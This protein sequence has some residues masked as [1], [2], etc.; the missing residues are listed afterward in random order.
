[1]NNQNAK[2]LDFIVRCV[3]VGI[4]T[5]NNEVKQDMAPV[6]IQIAIL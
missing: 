3:M 2:I 6:M 4:W 5:G 1:M